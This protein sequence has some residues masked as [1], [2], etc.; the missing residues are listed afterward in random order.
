MLMK[1]QQFVNF[2][3]HAE[4]LQIVNAEDMF[5]AGQTFTLTGQEDLKASVTNRPIYNHNR[6]DNKFMCYGVFRNYNNSGENYVMVEVPAGWTW[7]ESTTLGEASLP[8]SCKFK[9]TQGNGCMISNL[10]D[11]VANRNVRVCNF[12]R[13]DQLTTNGTYDNIDNNWYLYYG[14]TPNQESRDG[15]DFENVSTNFTHA[16]HF[17][18]ID[19]RTTPNVNRIKCDV[20]G[21]QVEQFKL[22]FDIV[23][24][25]DGASNDKNITIKFTTYNGQPVVL[26]TIDDLYALNGNTWNFT[27]ELRNPTFPPRQVE[28]AV[29]Y[30]GHNQPFSDVLNT[31]I[32]KVV[33]QDNTFLF[34]DTIRD[35]QY[36][37][38]LYNDDAHN[39]QVINAGIGNYII[40][41]GFDYNTKVR[42]DETARAHLSAT[43]ANNLRGGPLFSNLPIYYLVK[44][45]TITDGEMESGDNLSITYG[46]FDNGTITDQGKDTPL[47]RAVVLTEGGLSAFQPSRLIGIPTDFKMDDAARAEIE[48]VD[49][50]ETVHYDFFDFEIDENYSSPADIATRL[51]QQT[52]ELSNARV[53]YGTDSLLGTDIVGTKG[54]GIPQNKFIIPVWSTFD[55]GNIESVEDPYRPDNTTYGLLGIHRNGSYVLK[56]N[57]HNLPTGRTMFQGTAPGFLPNGE[58]RIYFR[59]KHTSI[60]KP[61]LEVNENIAVI[62]IPGNEDFDC[63]SVRLASGNGPFTAETHDE[64]GAVTG[65]PIQYLL[66]QGTY[67]SQY[68][69]SNNVSFGWDDSQS[70][71]TIS[72]LG[73][74]SVSDFDVTAGTGGEPAITVY[75]PSPVG[76]DNYNFLNTRTRDSGV[77]IVNWNS[78]VGGPT[79]LTPLAARTLY[80]VPDKYTMDANF[81]TTISTITASKEWFIDFSVNKDTVGEKFWR[82]LG[83]TQTQT[84]TT[85][86]GH[87]VGP[88]DGNYYPNGSTELELDAA[89]SILTSDDPSE[90]TPFYDT[91]GAFGPP[92]TAGGAPSQNVA[93][94]NFASIGGLEF[95]GHNVGMGVP[96]TAGNPKNFIRNVE[97]PGVFKV[98]D[99]VYNPDRE[100][101]NGYTLKTQP[102]VITAQKLP[103]KTEYGYYYMLS[104][105]VASDF[106][107][108]KDYGS[109]ENIIG[110]LS[111]LNVGGDYIFQ[112]Q[113]PQT[114]YAKRD[115]IIT[116]IKTTILTPK[117]QIPPA[118]DEFSSVIYQ[119]TRYEPQPEPPSRVPVWFQQQQAWGQIMNFINSVSHQVNPPKQTQA[120]R[121]Q[122]IIGEVANAVTTSGDQQAIITDR[123]L[124]NYQQLGLGKFKNDRQGMRQFLLENPEAQNFINDLSVYQ[125]SQNNMPPQE[126]SDPESVNPDSLLNSVLSQ[127]PQQGPN[128]LGTAQPDLQVLA[129]HVDDNLQNFTG[130]HGAT[131]EEIIDQTYNLEPI[132]ED[133]ATQQY[134]RKAE[135]TDPD[136]FDFDFDGGMDNPRFDPD[137]RKYKGRQRAASRATAFMNA[138][139]ERRAK[140]READR[141]QTGESNTNR[142]IPREVRT[143]ETNPGERVKPDTPD[144]GIGSAA[145][146]F[147]PTRE[148]S[149]EGGGAT[150]DE[151]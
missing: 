106:F 49:T 103:I 87:T 13:L 40:L 6:Y 4:A 135:N 131:V 18:Q 77:N 10:V 43:Y 105:I 73:Q 26:N 128:F 91:V 142:P 67:I 65:Y 39:R 115:A 112:Y 35:I 46:G 107:I 98:L 140:E 81:D 1:V 24:L 51:T 133:E 104:D 42:L 113:A 95:N 32:E 86:V 136:A 54:V 146:S 44:A 147:A 45:D 2:V 144:S 99:C 97:A 61:F 127:Q 150:K 139:K 72:N 90:N 84:E 60:N 80:S 79:G 31:N 21:D 82:K 76:K 125:H 20:L 33:G 69:G 111:K 121:I 148:S 38:N 134:I 19:T 28:T 78:Q 8:V 52:H 92:P 41:N 110:V 143:T 63:T 122:E 118:L 130:E 58:Y 74:S 34:K 138:E 126:I 137:R 100:E 16:T 123:I 116:S 132:P 83:F 23:S 59:T 9:V 71:F 7:A 25:A 68:C 22:Y 119:I 37:F 75:Y 30:G 55:T 53:N 88:V 48:S 5:G 50:I 56:K 141:Q 108:S 11:T 101:F 47:G 124:S 145:S 102:K 3:G 29:C 66:G 120:Q 129:D 85:F 15:D 70:R 114:F 151:K 109:Q 17:R 64:G 93:S 14:L 149:A 117:M 96:S 57:M 62:P 27:L 12:N 89:D 94:W 36:V